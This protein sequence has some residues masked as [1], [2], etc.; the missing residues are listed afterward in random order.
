MAHSPVRSCGERGASGSRLGRAPGNLDARASASS[1]S[2]QPRARSRRWPGSLTQLVAVA[3]GR[4][5]LVLASGG[6][7][8]ATNE[9]TL[10]RGWRNRAAHCS[11]CSRHRRTTPDR[12]RRRHHP[13]VGSL[14]QLESSHRSP[15]MHSASAEQGNSR[16]S[17]RVGAQVHAPTEATR[18]ARPSF[19]PRKDEHSPRPDCRRRCRPQGSI[20]SGARPNCRRRWKHWTRLLPRPVVPPVRRGARHFSLDVDTSSP[21]SIHRVLTASTGVRR[22]RRRS[23]NTRDALRFL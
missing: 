19:K 2:Q 21:L 5:G 12:S 3:S 6:L 4:E 23:I 8:R 15:G 20:G 18:A 10:K 16:P 1:V 7:G 14:R 22:S 11:R 9:H 17:G 13:Q